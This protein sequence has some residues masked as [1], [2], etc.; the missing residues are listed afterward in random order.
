MGKHTI[1]RTAEEDQY[2]DLS[3]MM[4]LLTHLLSKDMVE[5]LFAG[6]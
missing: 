1:D 4:E 6:G 5:Y 2:Q 3:T